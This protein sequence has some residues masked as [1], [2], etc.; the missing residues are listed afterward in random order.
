MYERFIS[1]EGTMISLGEH[2]QYVTSI[3]RN[4]FMGSSFILNATVDRTKATKANAS[5]VNVVL[6]RKPFRRSDSKILG[7]VEKYSSSASD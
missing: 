7:G 2:D 4:N 6:Q 3:S 5:A 1:S